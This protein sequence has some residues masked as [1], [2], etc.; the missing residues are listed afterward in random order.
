LLSKES[1]DLVFRHGVEAGFEVQRGDSH[2][3]VLGA[4]AVI[5]RKGVDLFIS[6]ALAAQ[7]SP[8]L[9]GAKFIWVGDGLSATDTDYSPYLFDQIKRSGIGDNLVF[10]PASPEFEFAV[11][12]SDVLALTSRLDPLPTVVID[13]LSMGRHVVCFESASGYPEMFEQHSVLST[14]IASYLDVESMLAKLEV[15]AKTKGSTTWESE[16][17]LIQDFAEERF[18]LKDYAGK[19]DRLSSA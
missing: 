19:L 5:F 14:G 13:S 8:S 4:G 9:N 3:R 6:L 15:L 11:Q 12:T 2:L 10:L 18:N 1:S 17:R 16:R 7:R